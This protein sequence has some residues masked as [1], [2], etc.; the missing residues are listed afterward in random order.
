M[1]EREGFEPSVPVKVHFLSRK[2]RSAT[3]APLRVASFRISG[4]MLPRFRRTFGSTARQDPTFL[5]PPVSQQKARFSRVVY[6]LAPDEPS[7]RPL[8]RIPPP[9]SSRC[10]A[11]ADYVSPPE[12]IPRNIMEQALAVGVGFEPT[13]PVKVLRFSR[14]TPSTTQ[15]PHRL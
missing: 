5:E 7:V 6:C 15:P 2:A 13:V 8:G 9:L 12:P 4:G 3:P 14:P 1:A 11:R 10:S